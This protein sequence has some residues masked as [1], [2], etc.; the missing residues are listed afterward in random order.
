L[1]SNRLPGSSSVRQSERVFQLGSVNSFRVKFQ[2][3]LNSSTRLLKW[4]QFEGPTNWLV[5]E[6]LDRFLRKIKKNKT[7]NQG[8]GIIVIPESE[9]L[10][11]AD[12][13]NIPQK[14]KYFAANEC[15]IPVGEESWS[16]PA[17]FGLRRKTLQ[18]IRQ[19]RG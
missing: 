2:V 5:K 7:E 10:R 18:N 19:G 8:E 15:H 9:A 12:K 1:D 17:Y 3:N 13:K 16:R 6:H 14:D 4:S 11:A